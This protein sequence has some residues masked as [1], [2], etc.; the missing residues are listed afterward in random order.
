[1]AKEDACQL[2]EPPDAQLRAAF[3]LEHDPLPVMQ[4]QVS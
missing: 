3:W 4:C 1:M 2:A